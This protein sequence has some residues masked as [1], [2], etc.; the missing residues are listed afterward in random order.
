MALG[1]GPASLSRPVPIVW[2][3]RGCFH[4]KNCGQGMYSQYVI[5]DQAQLLSTKKQMYQCFEQI[6]SVTGQSRLLPAS[7]HTFFKE[8]LQSDWCPDGFLTRSYM[9]GTGRKR[10][11]EGNGHLG[12]L[13]LS[14]KEFSRILHYVAF[15]FKLLAGSVSQDQFQFMGGRVMS[16]W[17]KWGS[18]RKQ[19]YSVGN[20]QRINCGTLA[21]GS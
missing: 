2:D 14:L 18:L 20:V 16:S 11:P 17:M 5:R 6:S 21:L 15:V 1:P 12:Q 10:G 7:Q 3:D 19:Q 9:F 8:C 4:R 13:N